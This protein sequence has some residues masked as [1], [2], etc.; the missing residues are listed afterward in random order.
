[1]WT[2]F[3]ASVGGSAAGLTGLTFI[4]VSFRFEAIA[5]SPQHRSRAA[6]VLTL[7]VTVSLVAMLVT[8]PQATTA[9]GVEIALCGV[10]SGGLL[11]ALDLRARRG[12]SAGPRFAL[13]C[14]HAAFA[15]GL[16]VGGL[17][18]ARGYNDA[19][20]VFAG[21]ALSGLVW[22]VFGAWTFLTHPQPDHSAVPAAA[23]VP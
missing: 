10:L 2:T 11:E 9:L 13:R 22:G 15:G 23:T 3:A 4:V 8:M 5:S 21:S 17:V 20:Y 18:L 19:L 7:F 12:S 14:V 6:Q 16:I 1:M